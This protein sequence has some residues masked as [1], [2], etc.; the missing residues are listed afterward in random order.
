MASRS[1]TSYQEQ[2]FGSVC[3]NV[4]C[5]VCQKQKKRVSCKC[6]TCDEYMCG[7]CENAHR[8]SKATRNHQ[9]Q[10]VEKLLKLQKMHIEDTIGDLQRVEAGIHKDFQ[11]LQKHG[12]NLVKNEQSQL[13]KIDQEMHSLMSLLYD[14]REDMKSKVR[15]LYSRLRGELLVKAEVYEKVSHE[16]EDKIKFLQELVEGQDSLGEFKSAEGVVHSVR[17]DVNKFQAQLPE[18]SCFIVAFSPLCFKSS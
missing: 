2:L 8:G 4:Y 16:M 11:S 1:T 9:F 5:E 6:I 12:K 17:Q 18:V 15:D 7:D 3:K 14:H 13:E 10:S